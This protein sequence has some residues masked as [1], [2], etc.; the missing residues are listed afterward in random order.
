[1][2]T[3]A[4]LCLAISVSN[5]QETIT[6]KLTSGRS[7]TGMVDQQTDNDR[8][9]LRY[10]TNGTTVI[11]PI[12]WERVV[13]AT[14]NGTNIDSP[15][16]IDLAINLKSS[17]PPREFFA[18]RS[19]TSNDANAGIETHS[20]RASTLDAKVA[21]V[22]FDAVIGNW[23]RDVEVDG[24]VINI[25]PVST[26]QELVPV[27]GTLTVSLTALVSRSFQEVP[28]GRGQVPTQIARWSKVIKASEFEPSGVNVRLPFQR[29]NPEFD[30][31]SHTYGLV[32]VKLVVPGQ[33]VFESSLDAMRI[34]PFAPTRDYLERSHGSR[35]LSKEQTGGRG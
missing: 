2:I 33:G 17:A 29:T 5:A 7:F 8:L 31:D 22:D 30:T 12:A 25:I 9:W 27:N 16:V 28:R 24:I 32:N 20:D 4:L 13:Q 11:R 6:V 19:N 1:M 35:F 34:R 14:H 23:D 15:E 3:L 26:M 21:S 10:G 18:S